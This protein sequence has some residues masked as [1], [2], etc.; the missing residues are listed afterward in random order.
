MKQSK[1][2]IW[3]VGLVVLTSM[4]MTPII[5]SA[6]WNPDP[7]D[8]CI[9]PVSYC[10]DGGIVLNNNFGYLRYDDNIWSTFTVTNAADTPYI[11]IGFLTE[12][13]MYTAI[14]W[15]YLEIR[16]IGSATG[17]VLLDTCGASLEGP[18]TVVAP[19]T[20]YPDGVIAR[21]YLP[22]FNLDMTNFLLKFDH[23]GNGDIIKI[24]AMN[25]WTCEW[26]PF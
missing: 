21:Y 11:G 4:V 18:S 24:D 8:Y 23:C 20:Y 5:A 19:L 16:V 10:L 7:F 6:D 17:C 25:V 2:T 3:L 26:Y 15:I 22:C 1:I 12:Q 14:Y 13:T 9:E